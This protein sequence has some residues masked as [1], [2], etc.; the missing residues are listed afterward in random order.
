MSRRPTVIRLFGTLRAIRVR[1]LSTPCAVLLVAGL[2]SI[3]PGRARAGGALPGGGQFVA[4]RGTIGTSGAAMTI[5]Q[6]GARAVIDW[7]S[8]SIGA[9]NSVQIDN[10]AGATLNRV[11][12]PA[13]SVIA[14]SLHATGSAYLINPSGVVIG[15]GGRVVTGGSFIASSRDVT[16][17]GFMAGGALAFS[18]SGPGAVENRGRIAAGG[19]VALIGASVGNAG[20]IL[21][22]H[23][24]AALAA[25][26]QV[27]LDPTAAD[28]HLLIATG[29]T[30]NVTNTGRIAAAAA[31]LAAAGGNVY[32]LA[33]NRGGL[34]Q[35]TGTATIGGQVWLTAGG[36]ATLAGTIGARNKDGSGGAVGIAGAQV[37]IAAGARIDASGSTGAGGRVVVRSK[38]VTVFA[39]TIA[40]GSSTSGQAGGFVEVS[41]DGRLDFT[42]SVDP[43]GAGRIG[44]LLL[45]PENLTIVATGTSTT[46][47]APGSFTAGVDNSVLTAADLE[48]ALASG[49]VVLSTGAGG[50]QSGDIVVAA[51]VAW[52]G[53]SS[54]TLDAYRNI[55]VNAGVTV[56]DTGSGN[57]VLRADT[58]GIGTGAVV[59][60]GTVDLSASTGHALIYYNPTSYATP[61]AYTASVVA[62]AGVPG[63]VA[64]YMLVNNA[65]ELANIATNLAGTYALG[66]GFAASAAAVAPI[67]P[68]FTG[69]FDGLGQTITG[70]KVSGTGAVGMFATIGAGASVVGVTLANET[71]TNPG[72]GDTGG[73]AGDN[74]GSILGV[75]V[76]GAISGGTGTGA[77]VGYTG[78][79]VG[80]NSGAIAQSGMVGSV[81]AAGTGG[82][83]GLVGL[84][85]GG[86]VTQSFSGASVTWT[87]PGGVGGP[88]TLGGLMGQLGGGT[89]TD[90]YATGHVAITA[91]N[92]GN[93]VR[94]GG[95][96]G[97]ETGGSIAQVLAVGQVS[98]ST[99]DPNVYM[100][101]LVGAWLGVAVATNA[102]WDSSTSG[103][104]TDGING[105]GISLSA[106]NLAT[107]LP[108]GFSAGTWQLAAGALFPY[109]AWQAP[110]VPDLISG[111]VVSTFI[112][113]AGVA[114]TSVSAAVNG[115]LLRSELSGGGVASFADGSYEFLLPGGTIGS[116][117]N[118]VVAADGG[119]SL[120]AG[121]TGSASGLTVA[122]NTVVAN[123][124]ST[125]V[126]AMVAQ[127]ATGI[128]SAV[129]AG[130]GA[131]NV[132]GVIELFPTN[133]VTTLVFS[134]SG[135]S[136]TMDDQ[137]DP[138]VPLTLGLANPTLISQTAPI[139][140]NALLLEGGNVSLTNP[141]NA[142][143]ELGGST[144]AL[145][146]AT[147]G[148]LKTANL[149][150]AVGLS[151]VGSLSIAAQ[152][153]ITVD[154]GAPLS[155]AGNGATA[156]LYADTGA[157]DS[158][159]V[160]LP[161]GVSIP[162][163]VLTVYYHSASFPNANQF[164]PNVNG[165]VVS[166]LLIDTPSDLQL[167]GLIPSG[168]YA[169]NANLDLSNFNFVPI[170]NFSGLLDG[171]G[172]TISNLTIND[173]G[174]GGDVGMI[175][176]NSGTLRNLSLL[177][178]A[179]T[180]TTSTFGGGVPIGG[181]AP[182]VG[183]NQPGGTISG[184][185]V[186]GTVTVAVGQGRGV[187]GIAGINDGLISN[188]LSGV[189]ISSGYGAY[190]G[191]IS[192]GNSGTITQSG[193]TGALIG[194]S[195]VTIGG[196]VASNFGTISQTYAT[197][198][199]ATS[200]GNAGGSNLGGLVAV[201]YATIVQS[202][203]TG[204]VNGTG[205]AGGN[206]GYN[207]GS[208]NGQSVGGLVGWNYGGSVTDSYALGAVTGGAS[209]G[210]GAVNYVGGLI[211]LNYATA[212][213]VY[214][215][216]PVAG[217]TGARVGA[218]AGENDGTITDGEFAPALSGGAPAVG[219][220]TG[221]ISSASFTVSPVSG[222]AR[223][224]SFPT[225]T[226]GFP[227]QPYALPYLGWQ[228]ILFPVVVHSA[229]GGGSSGSG[230]GSVGTGSHRVVSSGSAGGGGS[231]GSGSGASSGSAAGFATLVAQL[232]TAVIQSGAATRVSP[233]S[234]ATL[235]AS[236]RTLPGQSSSTAP[237]F[238]P[239]GAI[240]VDLLQIEQ[241][242]GL[243]W[244]VTVN[245]TG[246]SSGGAAQPNGPGGGTQYNF[247]PGSIV[248]QTDVSSGGVAALPSVSG[249]VTPTTF[250]IGSD[251][252][253]TGWSS[254][255]A[256]SLPTG[257][258]GPSESSLYAGSSVFGTGISADGA[259]AVALLGAPISPGSLIS[260]S[261]VFAGG[262]SAAGVSGVQT[263]TVSAPG[264]N[265]TAKP[266]GVG[267]SGPQNGPYSDAMAVPGYDIPTPSGDVA[268][269]FAP[270]TLTPGPYNP[271]FS[272]TTPPATAADIYGNPTQNTDTVQQ[273]DLTLYN[274]APVQ[275]PFSTL[276]AP[277]G[278]P[279]VPASANVLTPLSGYDGPNGGYNAS[280]APQD[281][282]VLQSYTGV[283]VQYPQTLRKEPSPS[284]LSAG[285]LAGPGTIPGGNP[286]TSTASSAATSTGASK[287]GA[288]KTGASKTGV[289]K[290]DAGTTGKGTSGSLHAGTVKKPP[291]S[292]KLT[293]ASTGKPK[294]PKVAANA[295]G[296]LQPHRLHPALIAG[297]VA[298]VQ[299]VGG[300]GRPFIIGITSLRTS[301]LYKAAAPALAPAKPAP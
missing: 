255:G 170:A 28:G 225:N 298:T 47:A 219:T 229:G 8:F 43:T 265:I 88:A 201:N 291:G 65:T 172:H 98:D 221:T 44:T 253:A 150:G 167:M 7:R 268:T 263:G 289:G 247:V 214:A 5:R 138:S 73:L 56:A 209:A 1:G 147:Q 53:A 260:G 40:A 132:N 235:G 184:V 79:L 194:P 187:G 126:S 165:T 256:G 103:W 80:T 69:V 269:T 130:I 186:G 191:G 33:G 89:I 71:V 119:Q 206:T 3:S 85:Y 32:A 125:T 281:Y 240:V 30:G 142:I 246:V 145:V 49:S 175:D 154:T 163:G 76:S 14:G 217:G 110:T 238:S 57:L 16:N 152:H 273:S 177:G 197:G 183:V 188:S 227:A 74:L 123:S 277:P 155:I 237:K 70:L 84:Q 295:A 162:N 115:S 271:Y 146:L 160:I 151:A 285:T 133:G 292:P 190:I 153:A 6:S 171:F 121:A 46:T 288:S 105:G 38:R 220:E 97:L 173:V 45:D 99:A 179:L 50:S 166:Y 4:G 198:T 176:D 251:A 117:R 230:S 203:A 10:G 144:A 149:A 78:G 116:G 210:G 249:P 68:V 91:L 181:V 77:S 83:G 199:V 193:A 66:R 93:E 189:A 61:T 60:N 164:Q 37:T 114:G 101:G 205:N 51:N 81:T 192:G 18:G 282:V 287:T 213:R 54:L 137:L 286:A 279:L 15:P 215:A 178:A 218:L 25:G 226:W 262:A 2:V 95:L 11:T 122:A 75:T 31:E 261:S 21:A 120:L 185:T 296:P 169:L 274:D 174:N 106:A 301:G 148:S 90:S 24:I 94:A 22:P 59:L 257:A 244:D 42:G 236:A 108:G 157:S 290:A 280:T 41:S 204:S 161:G 135:A 258:G 208:L 72:G 58:T 139:G 222:T 233:G 19:N 212:T 267:A 107:A 228:T 48:A 266:L 124:A 23:G 55:V 52:G 293:V 100:G 67:G 113:G 239:V 272:P 64:A 143:A 202:F 109:L 297:T 111:T 129:P 140:V 87:G 82:G 35:A 102:Y 13:A 96:L 63:Q 195:N 245:P 180:I 200:T 36:T 300:T 241:A 254:A 224:A 128:G 234:T 252:N 118:V 223:F 104:P 299:S 26:N 27:L 283:P 259:S 231:S 29:G 248:S 34:V 158:G 39:G 284:D 156:T 270:N 207:N 232:E 17:P 159:N 278:K 264:A 112:N 196:V 141:G 136:L 216:G 92:G 134:G 250:M 294:P 182:L 211:G 131:I 275:A 62:N 276:V 242:Y 12:G 243:G 20:S 86:S 127:Y 9:G 168:T